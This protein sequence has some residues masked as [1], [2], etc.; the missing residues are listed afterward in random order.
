VNDQ[1]SVHHPTH[2]PRILMHYISIV[3]SSARG[4]S[5]TVLRERREWLPGLD[6]IQ[7]WQGQNLLC[8]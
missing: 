4:L 7:E 3:Y 5:R 1:R 8:Y 6:S 2:Q